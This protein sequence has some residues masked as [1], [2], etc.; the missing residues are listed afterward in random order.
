M[1]Q[2]A[3]KGATNQY[4]YRSLSI[5]L[6]LPPPVRIKPYGTFT[7]LSYPSVV[8]PDNFYPV[9]ILLYTIQ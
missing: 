4:R 8:E 7:E 3:V 5:V 9:P 6:L 1:E 2:V